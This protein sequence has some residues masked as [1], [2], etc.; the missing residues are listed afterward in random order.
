MKRRLIFLTLLFSVAIL[1]FTAV[2]M[3]TNKEDQ[4][5]DRK[6]QQ[7]V[8]VNEIEQLAKLGEYEKVTEK[9]EELQES[10]RSSQIVSNENSKL[11]IMC[12]ICILFLVFVFSYVYVAILRPFEKMKQYAKHIAQGDFNVPLNYERSNYFGDFTWA[13]DSMRLEITKARSCEQEAILNN[14]TVIATLSHDIKTPIASIRAYAEGLEA[15]LDATP[16]KRAKYLKVLMKKCDEVSKLTNDLFLHSLS[17]LDKLKIET[18]PLELYSFME[19][20]V[21]EIAADKGDIHFVS[22]DSK[23]QILA[24][25]DRLL[26]ITENIINN[27]RKYAKSPID[28]TLKS[29]KDVAEIHFRDY[30]NGIPDEDMP[31]I[32]DKFYR[33]KNCGKEQG[34]GLGLYIVKYITEQMKGTVTLHSHEDGLEVVIRF[35][36]LLESS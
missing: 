14:K 11:L 32:F 16:E 24:D 26:Q 18:E 29:E 30:G 8:A 10:L 22:D 5:Q 31:F 36:V 34:S 28:I 13:F 7:I 25:R 12:G 35:P 6:E 3:V 19:E 1:S 15:N 33:G 2:C 27:A 21:T 4:Q 23:I 9:S 17:D 20:A